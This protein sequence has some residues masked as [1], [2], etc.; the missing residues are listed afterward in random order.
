MLA[1]HDRLGL[2]KADELIWVN[3]NKPPGPMQWSSKTRQ[4]LNTGYEPIYW[5]TNDPSALLSDNRRV[6]Q[7]HTE[8]HMAY[9]QSGRRPDR[10]GSDGAYRHTANS[11]KNITP[12]RIPRNVLN[13]SSNCGSQRQYKRLAR[14][15]GLPA[16]GAPMPLELAKFLIELMTRPGELV[17]DVFAG[18]NTTGLAAEIL[19]RP[20][21]STESMYEYALGSGFRFSDCNGFLLNQHL[22]QAMAA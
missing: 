16:H 6:L 18:S 3:P 19:G 17:V 1:L 14:D 12:G 22:Y 9:L 11:Y 10:V 13:F 20:W 2:Y 8:A 15:H 4:Q 5:L 7:P 21:L